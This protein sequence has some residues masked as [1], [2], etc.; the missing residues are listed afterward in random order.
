MNSVRDDSSSSD[1]SCDDDDNDDEDK[2][3][4]EAKLLNRMKEKIFKVIEEDDEIPK[5]GFFSLP[6]MEHA[7]KKRADATYEET[8]LDYE[9]LEQSLRK[10]EDDNSEENVDSIKE[11][12]KRTFWPV[13][14]AHEE[15]NK[16][17]KL[18]DADKN[19]DTE[20][21]PD[22][23]KHFDNGEVDKKADYAINKADDVQLG[24]A[25]LDDEHQNDLSISFD[26]IRKNPGPMIDI[27]A[28]MLA[29]NPWKKVK[30]RKKNGENNMKGS[31]SK[32]QTPSV[33]DP[34]PKLHNSDSVSEE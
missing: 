33:V 30:N 14:R 5:S 6:F 25:L 10:L 16:R 8:W 2:S 19:S 20:Y 22:S 17:P 34:N 9:E 23:G 29:D 21:D 27:E 3:K 28:G 4:L 1:E 11:T 31:K 13:K 18:G 26:G 32:V 7:M 15:A 12:G 24:T